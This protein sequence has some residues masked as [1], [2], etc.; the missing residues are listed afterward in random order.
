MLTGGSKNKVLFGLDKAQAEMAKEKHLEAMARRTA[1]AQVD[2]DQEEGERLREASDGEDSQ[3]STRS[4]R[5]NGKIVVVNPPKTASGKKG[6]K[7]APKRKY[8]RMFVTEEEK[9]LMASKKAAEAELLATILEDEE[10]EESRMLGY[11]DRSPVAD[12]PTQLDLSTELPEAERDAL[13]H[14]NSGSSE[15][16]DAHDGF[17]EEEHEETPLETQDEAPYRHTH[18]FHVGDDD[19][20]FASIA[21]ASANDISIMSTVPMENPMV[22][23]LGHVPNDRSELD[24]QLKLQKWCYERPC[25]WKVYEGDEMLPD[26]LDGMYTEL[27]SSNKQALINMYNR[28]MWVMISCYVMDGITCSGQSLREELQFMACEK[29]LGELLKTFPKG[30]YHKHVLFDTLPDKKWPAFFTQ[31]MDKMYADEGGKGVAWAKGYI[32]AKRV[33]TI[34]KE[35]MIKLF[36]G[37]KMHGLFK[38]A[39]GCIQ[40][41]LQPKWCR[42]LP[43]G[44]SDVSFMR[45]L[46]RSLWGGRAMELAKSSFAANKSRT[47]QD[48]SDEPKEK[49]KG[50]KAKN[51]AAQKNL[52]TDEEKALAAIAAE[53]MEKER[54]EIAE[55]N[56]EGMGYDWYPDYWMAFIMFG[57]PAEAEKHMLTSLNGGCPTLTID[58]SNSVVGAVGSPTTRIVTAGRAAS[59]NAN[60]AAAAVKRSLESDTEVLSTVTAAPESIT[61]NHTHSF[62]VHETPMNEL[63]TRIQFQKDLR[64][65]YLEDNEP[66]KAAEVTKNL[67]K[68]YESVEA[69]AGNA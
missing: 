50:G 38:D 10:E 20:P 39:K 57:R 69:R 32:G 41:Y 12:S 24:L 22:V 42:A 43:S 66:L 34:S 68:L 8:S 44:W 55:K 61:I 59:R 36:I 35:D 67:K 7:G 48:P 1:A 31:S 13:E 52:L 23:E 9:S 11:R 27:V 65:M 37:K 40:K 30:D 29:A 64:V 17:E 33:G 4:T 58:P 21:D 6:G 51:K 19:D 45:M 53:D 26:E 2:S 18:P 62:H 63:K 15:E 25:D 14:M 60:K 16:D 54:E 5:R 28:N 56:L 46:R 47:T 49:G 3:V